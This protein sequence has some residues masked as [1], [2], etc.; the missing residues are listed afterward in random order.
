VA[1]H[2]SNSTRQSPQ[3]PDIRVIQYGLGPIGCAIASVAASRPG[4]RLVGGIDIDPDKADRSLAEIADLPE[5]LDARVW[6]SAVQAISKLAP[7]VAL[8]ST[9]SSLPAVLDQLIPL[10]EA[11]VSIIST[12]EE[13]AYPFASYPTESARL[14]DTARSSGAALLGTGV[15]PGFVMDTL[16]FVLTAVAER[17]DRLEVSRVV[18]ASERR[19][20]LQQKIGAGLDLPEFER[21][22][23]RGTLRHV[24]L[25]ESMRLVAAALG[26]QL[27]SVDFT[28]E[29]IVAER[30]RRSPELVARVGQA[31]G[32][33]QVAIGRV[34]GEDRLVYDL[35]MM[36]EADDPGDAV[37]LV[38]NPSLELRVPGGIHG[39]VATAAIVVNAIPRILSAPP[40]LHTMLDIPPVV[41]WS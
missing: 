27:D 24:G 26:W 39:D 7:K 8:H 10:L 22:A 13:L 11:G 23:E 2:D 35:K 9:A 16:A 30:E 28:L 18:D 29:P 20:P 14:N 4:L 12:C 37:H 34:A 31:A 15:N 19:L 38:G 5:P 40:G 33:H 25:E 17:V 21:Q 1:T 3:P 6:P 36:L 41:R 32:V